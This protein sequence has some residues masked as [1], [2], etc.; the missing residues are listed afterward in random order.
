MLKVRDLIESLEKKYTLDEGF[1]TLDEAY[2]YELDDELDEIM[3]NDT[4]S[5]EEKEVGIKKVLANHDELNEDCLK[6]DFFD[7]TSWFYK[8]VDNYETWS[9]EEWNN[10][11]QEERDA[12]VT[13]AMKHFLIDNQLSEEEAEEFKHDLSDN[14]FHTECRIFSELYGTI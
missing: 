10:W 14:N 3:D 12:A 8:L 11:S 6:E 13:K 1:V 5:D 7:P 4:L 9:G 2:E